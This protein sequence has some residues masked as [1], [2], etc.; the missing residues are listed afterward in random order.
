MPLP[1]WNGW[2]RSPTST[3]CSRSPE[4]GAQAPTNGPNDPL[5]PTVTVCI[6]EP[7]SH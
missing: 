6:L 1:T 4:V 2:T 3:R 5:A 7:I